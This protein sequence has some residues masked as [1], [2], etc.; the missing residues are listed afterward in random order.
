MTPSVGEDADAA[1]SGRPAGRGHRRG[2]ACGCPS[3][4]LPLT[5]LAA[6]LPLLIIGGIMGAMVLALPTVLLC[7]I[8]ASLVECFLVLPGHLRGSLGKPSWLD[9]VRWRV[10][11]NRAF[12][13]FRDERAMA[14]SRWSLKH[15]GTTVIAALCGLLLAVVLIATQHVPFNMVMGFDFESVKADVQFAST[16]TDADK[17]RFIRHLETTLEDVNRETGGINV[18]GYTTRHNMAALGSDDLVG[19]QYASLEGR[20]AFEETRGTDP[21]V[22]VGLWRDRIVQPA[23]VEQLTV[24]VG[25]GQ[26]N[27]QP[28]LTMVLRGRT[29]E[30][31]KAGAQSLKAVLT[32]YP[33]V[34]NVIDDL[35]FGKE[36][37]VFALSPRGRALGLTTSEVGRQLR[38]AYDGALVQI[39]NENESEVEVRVVLP[40]AEQ[41]DLGQLQQF[42]IKTASGSLVPLGNVAVLTTRRGID[43]IR[44]TDAQMAVRVSADVDSNVANAMSITDSIRE[45][46]LPAILEA[47]HLTFGLGGKSEQDQVILS[48]MAL[49]GMLTLLLIYLILAWTFASWLWPLAIMMAIPF[50]FTGAVFGHWVTG[51]DVGAMSLLAFFAL[52]GIVVNDSI[53]LVSFFRGKLTEGLPLREALESAVHARFRAVILTSLTTVAG[54]ASLMFATSSLAFML[55]PIAV[56]LVFG[57]AYATSL[58]LF[59]IPA[60]ILLLEHAFERGRALLIARLP[61]PRPIG[62][63]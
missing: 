54:L 45:T 31:V 18:E 61:N 21:D 53:V 62:E 55:A 58:V 59:V 15:P 51:W 2:A 22:F 50:G 48:T 1:R 33:G 63:A 24:K 57:L 52:T 19:E 32:A 10:R 23:Y 41:E 56:T 60:L 26:N 44:H 42:P 6:F 30:D 40:E 12:T 39:F 34:S 5:T 49:G 20:Y 7:V 36:Q 16:A 37:I 43:I 17:A 13:R 46:Q 28:D 27:G 38:A 47:N 3:S 9:T 35:P 11:F 29:L 14:W 4:P 8:V 25:G